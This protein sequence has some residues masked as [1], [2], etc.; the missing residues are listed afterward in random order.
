M[1]HRASVHDVV[2]AAK[3]VGLL[4]GA[5]TATYCCGGRLAVAL[6]ADWSLAI[7]ADDADRLRIEACLCARVVATMWAFAGDDQRLAELVSAALEETAAL[8]A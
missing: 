2:H 8:T 7:S 1:T 6:G 3:L 4:V 5:T